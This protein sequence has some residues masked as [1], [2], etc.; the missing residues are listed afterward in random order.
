[1]KMPLDTSSLH[2]AIITHFLEHQHAP[3][4]DELAMQFRQPR[5]AVVAGLRALQD[6]HG[7]VL[8]PTSSEVW[9][10]HPFSTA[11]TN[12]WVQSPEGQLVG[13]LCMVFGGRRHARR[14]CHDNDDPG[15]RGAPGARASRARQAAR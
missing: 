4:I 2:Y 13:K 11:P 1:M 7:V 15:S 10:V 14:R 6:Y 8:H 3:L 12:F 5:E 9:V